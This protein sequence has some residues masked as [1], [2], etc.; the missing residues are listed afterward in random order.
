MNL[1]F[2]KKRKRKRINRGTILCSAREELSSS[3]FYVT[4]R[5]CMNWIDCKELSLF[6]SQLRRQKVQAA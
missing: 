1:F 4:V 2:K 6:E 3:L 5:K